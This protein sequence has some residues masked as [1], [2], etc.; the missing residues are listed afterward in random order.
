MFYCNSQRNVEGI[1]T[2][3]KDV[4]FFDPSI[5]NDNN[6]NNNN[7]YNINNINN[8]NNN[9]NNNNNNNQ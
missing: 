4:I 5:I 8:Y 3:R 2:L 9:N 7:N 6:N 1:L